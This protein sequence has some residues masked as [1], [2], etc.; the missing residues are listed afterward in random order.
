[1]VR[2]SALVVAALLLVAAVPATAG[3]P[4]AAA[5]ASEEAAATRAPV[6]L[7]PNGTPAMLALD[8]PTRAGFGSPT[9]TLSA[10]L[11]LQTASVDGRL[12][13][14]ALDVRFER[15]NSTSAAQYLRDVEG[16]IAARTDAL[17]AAER[18]ARLAYLNGS[19][20]AGTTLRR[21][22]RIGVQAEH[23]ETLVERALVYERGISDTDN[24]EWALKDHYTR[25]APLTGP[26]RD[27][28]VRAIEGEVRDPRIYLNVSDDGVVLSAI[29]GERYFREAYRLDNIDVQAK[30]RLADPQQRLQEL[31]PWAWSEE[32]ALTLSISEGIPLRLN[33]G[34]YNATVGYRHGR[35]VGYVDGD[36]G[37]VFHEIQTKALSGTPLFE[38][39]TFDRGGYVLN[40][41]PTYPGGPV[42]VSLMGQ[43]GTPVTGEVRVDGVL[44]GQTGE[45]PVWTLGPPGEYT[46]T[47]TRGDTQIPLILDPVWRRSTAG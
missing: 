10:A 17:V 46:I 30:E 2:L 5:V 9:V 14:H 24:V 31:Y 41:T 18:R 44:V 45:D 21:F 11:E 6:A 26:V 47:A 37:L 32:N 19:A 13:V 3:P 27:V 35:L 28:V 12:S 25:L 33:N 4:S 15:A 7:A 8:G 36:T 20:D 22:A 1:M 42:R 16:R 29:R 39:R 40:A 23:T 38:A 34:V 43:E